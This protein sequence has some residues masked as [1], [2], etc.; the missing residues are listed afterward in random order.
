VKRG[1]RQIVMAMIIFD[2]PPRQV[3]RGMIVDVD[4]RCDALAR[5]SFRVRSLLHP[6]A[7]EIADGLGAPVEPRDLFMKLVAA[8]GW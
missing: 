5:F 4:Q 2:Q 7:G 6:G 1:Q 8:R 3:A